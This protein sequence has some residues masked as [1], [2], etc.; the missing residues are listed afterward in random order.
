MLKFPFKGRIRIRF[1][2]RIRIRFFTRIRIR[3][4][5]WVRI[6]M[7]WIREHCLVR[8]VN[9]LNS[10]G[11]QYM[12]LIVPIRQI[13]M[14]DYK[15]IFNTKILM[16][17]ELILRNV[18]LEQSEKFTKNVQV[19]KRKIFVTCWN[20]HCIHLGANGFTCYLHHELILLKWYNMIRMYLGFIFILKRTF[21]HLLLHQRVC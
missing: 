9:I 14:L 3:F 5:T 19:L 18:N 11:R 6:I 16:H 17:W 1:F 13:N 10:A 7:K 4:F 15:N 21:F 20:K 12:W 2:T 8:E